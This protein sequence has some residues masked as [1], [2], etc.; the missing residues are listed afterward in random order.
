MLN[1]IIGLILKIFIWAAAG[2][3]W[4]YVTIKN[5]LMEQIFCT[6]RMFGRRKREG[7]LTGQ[8]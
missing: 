3:A 7:I 5:N 1:N 4:S 2:G 8:N 6:F